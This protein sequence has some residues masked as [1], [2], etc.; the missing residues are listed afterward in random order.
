VKTSKVTAEV[1]VVFVLKDA[2]GEEVA[3][4]IN[5]TKICGFYELCFNKI[6]KVLLSD[7]NNILRAAFYSAKVFFKS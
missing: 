4:P 7:F 2:Q 5:P 1:N 3:R 6:A